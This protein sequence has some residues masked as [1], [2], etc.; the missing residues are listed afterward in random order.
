MLL[1]ITL[2]TTPDA[3]TA[4][5]DSLSGYMW[6]IYP[7]MFIAAW[8][9]LGY[10]WNYKY[11][12][13]QTKAGRAT[14]SFNA[15][16]GKVIKLAFFEDR[17][18][19]T[20]IKNPAAQ[21]HATW[22][23]LN[24]LMLGVSIAM[25]AFG[26]PNAIWA[27][28][29]LIVIIAMRSNKVFSARHRVLMRM[30]EVAAVEL[31]YPRNANLSPWGWVSIQKWDNLTTPG[32][33]HVQFPASYKS[34]DQRNRDN[35]ERHF[36]GTVTDDNTWVYEW[37][38]SQ[39]TVICS[40]VEHIPTMAHYPGSADR[41]WNEIPIGLG[42]NGEVVWDIKT[43]PH[44]LIT[45][46]T[47]GG[48]EVSILTNILTAHGMKKIGD[49]KV[50]DILFD[51]EGN[52]T[53]VTHLHP[54]ITPAKAYEMTFSNG[55]KI[56]ADPDHL[57]E[58]ET[59]T[60]R[61]SRFNG[62]KKEDKRSRSYWLDKS[63]VE[64]LDALVE[65]T[66]T[67]E[68]IAISEM[69]T[70]IGKSAETGILHQ[71]A[72]EIGVAEEIRPKVKYHYNAQIVK[73]KQNVSYI[74]SAE[75]MSI[76]NASKSNPSVKMPISKN[77]WD[78]LRELNNEL[79][80]SDT[81]T[82][83]SI[84]EYLN[85]TKVTATWIKANFDSSLALKDAVA[86]LYDKAEKVKMPW[87]D[88]IFSIDSEYIN[89]RQFATLIDA[90]F[91]KTIKSKF[92]IIKKQAKD[93]YIVN[94]EVELI[95]PEKVVERFG[96]PY[97]VYPKRMFIERLLQHNQTPLNDQRHKRIFPEIRTT[98]DIV[99]TLRTTGETVYTNH[100]IRK[101]APL[102][103]PEKELPI[104]PYALGAWL[105]DGFSSAGVICGL[106]HQVF[107]Y[108]NEIGYIATEKS[109]ATKKGKGHDDFRS[110]Y[111]P[112]LA[113]E[114]RKEGLLLSK[115]RSI[116]VDGTLKKIPAEYLTASIEQRRELLRGL[117]DT[118]GTVKDN[119][120]VQLATSN[121]Q[122]RDDA[123]VLIASLGY[124]PFVSEKLPTYMSQGEKK[125]SANIAYTLTFQADPADRLFHLDRKN[126]VHAER[127]NS[128][129]LH[130]TT[131]AHYIVDIREVEPVPMRCIS[132]DS[133]TRLFA[134]GNSLIPTHNSTIQR[135]LIFHCIQHS[136]RW[137][138][139]GVDVK[140][141]ELKP[142]K[143][144]DSAVVGIATNV[145]DGVEICRFARDEMMDRYEKMEDLGVNHFLD[146][147]NPPKALMVMIDESYMFLAP[148]GIKT[149]EGKAEDEIKGEAS[150]ILGDIARLGRASGVH[151]VL[152]TQ[153]P[154]AK[155]IYG[156]LKQNLA[157]RIAAG[158]MDSI[159]SSMTLD[160]ENAT[161][162]P[163][164][165]KG[166]G[167]YQQ[168]GEGEQFQGYFAP[169]DWIDKWLA[170]EI[171][172]H[173]KED[174]EAAKGKGKKK[175]KSRKE[176]PDATD[177]PVSITSVGDDKPKKKGGLLG[178]IQAFNDS[179][180]PKGGDTSD[181]G[182]DTPVPTPKAMEDNLFDEESTHDF[183]AEL[184]NDMKSEPVDSFDDE[185]FEDYDDN[186]NSPAPAPL[187]QSLFDEEDF[188]FMNDDVIAP[189][190]APKASPAQ[191]R[192]N[193]SKPMPKPVRQ[194]AP[195][196][197]KPVASAPKSAVSR[198][199]PVVN[200]PEPA[201]KPVA[202]RPAGG[203]PARPKAPTS[204]PARPTLPKRPQ[205]PQ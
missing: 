74:N 119:G 103:L 11:R 195:A 33:T 154:D 197:E 53:K 8:A 71:I 80:D 21:K 91:N 139:L 168:F 75:F 59:R 97:Y 19:L 111:F 35:F 84:V 176:V 151:L 164:G 92:D 160:N 131:D 165:I 187:T 188:D 108:M 6:A 198:P 93:T 38:T 152:A 205:M 185:D 199:A 90:E 123:K 14:Q 114:L 43:V 182:K 17:Y 2:T 3:G 140:R 57:W 161:R 175:R 141:V 67:E 109:L 37:K 46:T 166:R 179:H 50:G 100:S 116:R 120:A 137:S 18:P 30:F 132:V 145:E 55:E 88:K 174:A 39:S 189:A 115:G 7:I 138:F 163:G 65:A 82:I 136:D 45:G 128:N 5:A 72:K 23:N 101:T 64:A 173:G 78:K 201:A 99:D 148:S 177:A 41:E 129:N 125:T 95:V 202:P 110:V 69:A 156:E 157:A 54:I 28:V 191:S 98:Q 162:L 150:K 36:N 135:N 20:K 1:N 158:R 183:E 70:L 122:L 117:L 51:P 81:M 147:P 194:S 58:T 133:P 29:F 200:K 85:A 96:N 49:L 44:A 153:R 159:A 113:R 62:V 61:L 10:L 34:E 73:Q 77:Q 31:K 102:N 12:P 178:K 13:R 106:D 181:E 203:V 104:H 190:P 167:F 172:V 127:F 16:L 118:D 180:A 56:V 63:T 121:P 94:E 27:W 184:L 107:E 86:D 130:S 143:Q 76:Y 134:V 204:L 124:L 87:P 22:R 25:S 186:L 142:Y 170:G 66:G 112:K 155:V 42:A 32:T 171:V 146:L 126:K 9:G 15:I 26:S 48:K 192:P 89:S 47:G 60:A 193:V 83:D 24:R 196:A 40:P 169:Q 144:Y 4:A 68:T 105:G 149:D 52:P 79:R